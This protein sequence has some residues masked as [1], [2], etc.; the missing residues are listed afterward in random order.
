MQDHGS[1]IETSSNAADWPRAVGN[2]TPSDYVFE[3]VAQLRKQISAVI[4]PT[5][6]IQ[7]DKPGW[8]FGTHRAFIGAVAV[9]GN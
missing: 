9:R 5:L 7:S 2:L 1:A 4:A 8:S 6:S 3:G